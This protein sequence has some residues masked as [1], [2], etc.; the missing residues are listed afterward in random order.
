MIPLEFELIALSGYRE[1]HCNYN[2]VRFKGDR[3]PCRCTLEIAF[4]CRLI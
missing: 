1:N 3:S 4:L 2:A